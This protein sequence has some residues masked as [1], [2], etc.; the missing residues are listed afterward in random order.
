MLDFAAYVSSIEKSALKA[1]ESEVKQQRCLELLNRIDD[2]I[3]SKVRES[4]GLGV[5]RNSGIFFSD[6]ELRKA[7]LRPNGPALNAEISAADPAVGAGDLLL[8]IAN[9]LPIECDLPR[10]LE[11]WGSTFAARDVEPAFIRLTKVRLALAAASR[12]SAPEWCTNRSFQD[13][14]P[15]IRVGDGLQFLRNA[16]QFGH[17]IMNPPFAMRDAP[18]CVEWATGQ[19]NMAALFLDAAV[20]HASEGTQ[21]IAIL[22]DVIRTGSRYGR[23]R[24]AVADHLQSWRVSPYG[25][26]DKWTDVDV[27][28]LNAKVG[29]PSEDGD[30]PNWWHAVKGEQLQR[31]YRVSVGPVVPHRDPEGETA[32]PFLSVRSVPV[33]GVIDVSNVQKRRFNSRLF[34][35]PFVVVRRTSRPDE[36]SR[37]VG[38]L[39]LGT[40]GVLVENHLLV[41]QP[42]RQSRRDCDRLIKHLDSVEAKNWL[43]NRIRCRHLTVGAI[44]EM[45]MAPK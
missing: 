34:D 10:T 29:L 4:I 8:E 22:P 35:P 17:I 21:L 32:H 43:N 3:G 40:V 39:I 30:S 14:F 9:K 41:I 38:T 37:G 31:S 36:Q 26:F 44:R 18:E 5:R 20:G 12:F 27:F 2:E 19:T 16:K 42:K 28:I 45:P 6:S 1:L 11:A 15:Q 13:L 7:A 24:G 33:G 25:Q 23:L